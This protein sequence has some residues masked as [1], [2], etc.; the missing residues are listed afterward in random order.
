MHSHISDLQVSKANI[1]FM[2]VFFITG[3]F[4]F[5]LLKTSNHSDTSSFYEKNSS[6]LLI[7]HITLPT[8]INKKNNTL[9][10]N[11]FSNQ[12]NPDTI[13]GNLT[14]NISDHYPA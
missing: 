5:D 2:C 11:I 10:D 13:S 12:Y 4:N 8:R 9:I 3:D 1:S 14:V 6:N 7:P